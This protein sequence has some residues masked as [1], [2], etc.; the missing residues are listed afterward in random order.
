[1]ETDYVILDEPT[2]DL[3]G[4]GFEA[5]VEII[6]KLR[7]EGRGVL[8]ITHDVELALE[9]SDRAVILSNGRV[10]FE[11]EPEDLLSLDLGSYGLRETLGIRLLRRG[12]I[13]R[14]R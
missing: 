10:V 8:L 6:G 4:R 7:R 14:T 9:A 13:E 12:S 11:E 3:D 1:M 2:S 5:V